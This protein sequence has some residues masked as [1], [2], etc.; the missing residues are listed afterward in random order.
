M[1]ATCRRAG[2]AEPAADHGGSVRRRRRGRPARTHSGAAALR[3]AGP[4]GHH[5]KRRRRRRHDGLLAGVAGGARRLSVRAR[6]DRHP[7]AEPVALQNIRSTTPRP[8]SRPVALVAE[9]PILLIARK[10]FP[11]D[12]LGEFIA[13]A[14]ANQDKMQFGSAGTGAAVHL[15]CVLLNAAIGVNIVHV[16]YRGTAPAMQDLIAGRIDYQ[17]PVITPVVPQ[18]EGGLVKALATLTKDPHPD[19]AEPRHRP[20]AGPRG[21]RSL[22]LVRD[23]PAQGHAGRHRPQTPAR[24]R[25]DGESAGRAGAA[26][27]TSAPPRSR[28]SAARRNISRRSSSARS[29]N[30]PRPS[31]PAASGWISAML[32][33]RTPN[34]GT[35]AIKS[36]N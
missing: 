2:V 20:G 14:R 35:A 19:I 29:R 34:V 26:E 16:P 3:T 17:C 36:A 21:F 32:V 15:A 9:Q 31:R 5:R 12:N 13:Y 10:N 8:I 1:H 24:H 25:G 22:Y 27:A 33:R 30:G 28:P 7:C 6:H 4:A 18:I 23:L 11:A